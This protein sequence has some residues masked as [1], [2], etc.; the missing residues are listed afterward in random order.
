M[1]IWGAGPLTKTALTLQILVMASAL[2]QKTR[3][4]AIEKYAGDNMRGSAGAQV[5]AL[6]FCGPPSSRS[7]PCAVLFNLSFGISEGCDYATAPP[8]TVLVFGAFDL[9]VDIKD[10]GK[11]NCSPTA[12]NPSV[13]RAS[14]MRSAW[15]STQRSPGRSPAQPEVLMGGIN[16][17]P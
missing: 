16:C 11:E 5:L 10:E 2:F 14:L 3:Q 6:R 13:S 8:T 7:A 1:G 12:W 15:R 17:C 9:W 4:Q